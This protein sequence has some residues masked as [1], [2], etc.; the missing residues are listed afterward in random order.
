MRNIEPILGLIIILSCA[1]GALYEIIWAR[2]L[3]LF[4]GSPVFAVSAV[5]SALVG[6]LGLGSFYFGRLADGETRP[7]RVYAF[8]G[9]GLGIFALIFPTLLDILNAIC[10]LIY[11]GL[12][13]DFYL[14]SWIRFVLSCTVLLIPSTLIG[15]ALLLLGR[16]AKERCAGFRADRLFT[17]NMLSA[18]IGCIA[19]GFF[20][21]QLLGLQSSIYLGVAINLILAGVAFS[22]DRSW[23]E[24]SV[25]FQQNANDE[26]EPS[27]TGEMRRVVLW[28]FA[29]SGFCAIGYAVLWTR[30]LTA[31]LGSTGH[32]FSV[33]LTALL[34]GVTAGSFLSA[35]IGR[36][37]KPLINLFGLIQ[38]AVGLSIV[39][40]IPAF[41][42]LSGISRG[43]QAA[44]GA[45]RVWEFVAGILLM[46][47][48]AILIGA[49]FPLARRIC[50]AAESQSAVYPFSTIGALL[51]SLCTGFIL[52]PL[53][54][55]R[56]SLILTAG[57]NAVIGCALILRSAEKSQLFSGTAIGG[58]IL[59][60]GVGLM[61]LLWGSSPPFLKNGTFWAQ[62]V[63]DTLVEY[64]ET[65]DANITT[66]MDAQGVHRIY[67]DND[68]IADTSRR[69]STL[70][71]IIAHLPLLLHPNPDRGLVLG[72]A[73]GITSHT[74]TQHDV[75]VDT[76][77]NPNGLIEAARKHFT[78]VNHNVLDSS[79]F[80]CVVND[81]RNYLLMTSK[82][83]DVISMGARHPLMSSRS[84]N[85]YT[86][87]FYRWC[88]R[89]LTEDGIICQW[90]PLKRLPETHLKI[91]LRTFVEVF[92]NA[93]V[94][95]KYTP[96]FAILIGTP[97]RLKINYQ[98][99]MERAQSPRVHEALAVDDLDG[100]SLLDS[101]MMGEKAVRAYAGDG[102]VHTDN[103]PHLEFVQLRA[104][105]N[106]THINI[107]G[108]A[109]YRERCTSYLAN[110][111][112]T[113]S[114]KIEVRKR[115]DLYFD[116]TQKLIEGQIEY[117]KG[118]YEKAVG[119]L[120]QAVAINPDDNTI[121]YN[122]GAAVELATKDYQ[123]ELN[124]TEKALKQALQSSPHD[125]QKQ[126][127]LGITHELQGELAKS[128][129]AF[130][131]ALKYDPNRLELYSL[132]G[133]IYER[134]E[135]YDEALRTYQRLEQLE[136]NLPAIIFGAMA[137]IYHFHKKMLPEAL[138]YAQKALAADADSWRVHNLLG[139][140]YT[141]KKEFEQAAGAFKAAMQLAPNE[142]MPH[143]D[144]AK[145]YLAQGR[146]DEALESANTAI[147]LA[148][149][150][151]YLQEQRRQIE[152]A[153]AADQ[154]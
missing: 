111:G 152:S 117:A 135:R 116:A 3:I 93:T 41:G 66:F 62:R 108:L 52:I 73:M 47:V 130:E 14:L 99:F 85:L 114:D 101:F 49:S 145:A 13:T 17:I 9:V 37:V 90:I 60:G 25:D 146:Y 71:R 123:E 112:R 27:A 8:L 96:D 103:H 153:I 57:L 21:I 51:G 18:S 107:A 125:V 12:S 83:Y 58:T 126:V 76:V 79:L 89:I 87:D 119:V 128:A 42:N 118:E 19:V 88:K 67:I 150:D 104:L 94:W 92:P 43:L 149:R 5:L 109:K 32:A 24:T 6:G 54:G 105:A 63:N 45:G 113:M 75:R 77:E 91:I 137:S 133:P 38:I 72:F 56:P 132:L 55:I 2:Q 142:P 129:N 22:L 97:E 82:R 102:P 1:C 69:G 33:T 35:A 10:V 110:Y 127:E 98:R 151:P 50:A 59:T 95:Y 78:D 141:D 74:M 20:L 23:S 143:S 31:F 124:R 46:I 136:P 140:I 80:N 64:T 86:A 115:I 106:T 138:Q 65:V 122:L 4:F 154:E 100:M 61:V 26:S 29:V 15:G 44:F 40:L 16:S 28:T 34:L 147:R 144:L 30:L 148:P 48:P 131:E 81:E 11:R 139:A 7:L 36:R 84:S 53:I 68:E 120:N 70:H 121:R 134:Q 39:A